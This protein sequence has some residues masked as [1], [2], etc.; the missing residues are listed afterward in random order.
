MKLID[1][2]RAPNPR[3]VNIFLAEKGIEVP[4]EVLNLPGKEHL[5]P[6]IEGTQPAPD[7]AN[8]AT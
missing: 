8:P 4:S 5:T 3:R 1:Q 2:P 7:P 6:E